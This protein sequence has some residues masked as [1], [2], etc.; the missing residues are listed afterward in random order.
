MTPKA[1]V[2]DLDRTLTGTDLVLDARVPPR[3][4]ELRAAGVRVVLATGRT[5]EDLDDRGLPELVDGVVAENGCLVS[6]GGGSLDAVGLGFRDVA[7]TAM[8][9]LDASFHWGRVMGSGPRTL[10]RQARERLREARVGHELSYNADEVM[11]LPPGVSKAS[12]VGR[13]L[14][15]LGISPKDAWAIGDG[16]NDVGMLRLAGVGAVP[17]NATEEARAVATVH[18][19]G[20]YAKGFLDLTEPI[21]RRSGKA[22]AGDAVR[23]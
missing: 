22:A 14:R 2:T 17:A 20:A 10:A 16:E 1:I 23:S 8:G 7:R 19:I 4:A 11:I 15:E 6:V 9:D 13:C 3:I 5:L 12:G 18:L 21:L